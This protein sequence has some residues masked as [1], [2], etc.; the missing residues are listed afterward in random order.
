VKILIGIASGWIG[1]YA[2]DQ[3][4]YEGRLVQVLPRLARGIAAGFGFHF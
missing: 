3:V 4:M 2:A 1:F